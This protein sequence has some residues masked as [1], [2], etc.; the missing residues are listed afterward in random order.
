M[1]SFRD[2]TGAHPGFGVLIRDE[3][4]H[5]SDDLRHPKPA[6][7][8]G[9]EICVFRRLSASNVLVAG[10]EVGPGDVQGDA[11]RSLALCC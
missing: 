1:R 2:A 11:V 8:V 5:E 4:R 7:C 3:N 10:T 9:Q 6:F